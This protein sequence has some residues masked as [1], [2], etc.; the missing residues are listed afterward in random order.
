MDLIR[1]IFPTVWLAISAFGAAFSL[2]LSAW[3]LS[4]SWLLAGLCSVVTLV[5]LLKSG[6]LKANGFFLVSR[7]TLIG[8]LVFS[9]LIIAM[10]QSAAAT[11][12]VLLQ[13]A[14]W[15]LYEFWYSPLK[16]PE[17]SRFK[18][19]EKLPDLTFT[20]MDGQTYSTA[21]SDLSQ[22]LLFYRGNWCGV[23]M[24]QVRQIADE[25]HKFS[26]KK[27]E[28]LLISNQPIEEVKR[29]SRVYPGVKRFLVDE[30][31]SEI[32]RLG[33]VHRWATPIHEAVIKGFPRDSV[34]PTVIAID[35]RSRI[36]YVD[37]T[38][39][40]RIRPEPEAFLRVFAAA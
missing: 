18:I 38:E 4:V 1:S 28:I 13:L 29:L 36:L 10:D 37:F 5:V 20:Q 31:G 2:I 39:E 35:S 9:A 26:G 22:L 23:C 27:V 30:H 8:T 24:A 32:K 14:S 40:Y 15:L 25:Y 33:L 17:K 11:V 34:L 7:V 16:R 21:E 3:F 6:Q 12:V 19:G